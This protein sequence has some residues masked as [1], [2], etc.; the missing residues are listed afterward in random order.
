MVVSKSISSSVA[1]GR[2]SSCAFSANFF[3]RRIRSIARLRAVV[4]SHAVGLSGVPSFGQ[5]SA[6]IAKAS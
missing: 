1:S 3:S 6:A 5:R 2:S 4:T